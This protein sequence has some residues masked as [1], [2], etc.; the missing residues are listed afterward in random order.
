MRWGIPYD[1]AL[2]FVTGGFAFGTVKTTDT[3][4]QVG[5]P[6]RTISTS[7]FQPGGAF[8]GGVDF[9][10]TPNLWIRGEYIFVLLKNVNASIPATPGN[11]DDVAV[12]HEYSDNIFR[13]ALSY[14]LSGSE[15]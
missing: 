5:L 14:R 10:V 3:F 1:R 13:M 7:N 2:F 8:G 15:P 4:A 9:A 11:A 12:T 6:A